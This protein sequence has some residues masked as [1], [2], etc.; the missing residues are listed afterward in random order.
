MN[1]LGIRQLILRISLLPQASGRSDGRVCVLCV[2][3]CVCVCVCAGIANTCHMDV[4]QVH[5]A[6]NKLYHTTVHITPSENPFTIGICMCIT[7]LNVYYGRC[8]LRY[9]MCITVDVYYGRT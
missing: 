5:A 8:V 3:V 4:R 7:V 9:C 1:L 6:Q 2:C